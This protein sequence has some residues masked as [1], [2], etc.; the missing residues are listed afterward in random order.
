LKCIIPFILSITCPIYFS[1]FCHLHFVMWQSCL[2]SV[3]NFTFKCPF[4]IPLVCSNFCL[5][6]GNR[7]LHLLPSIAVGMVVDWDLAHTWID[8]W[9]T[10]P[11]GLLWL[12]RSATTKSRPMPILG[13][14]FKHIP[15]E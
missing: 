5:G 15:W 13:W 10:S 3:F 14:L 8:V 6:L 11:M 4:Y 9:P 12:Q 1:I 7:F 2:P